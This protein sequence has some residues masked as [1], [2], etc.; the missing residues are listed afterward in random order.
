I[1]KEVFR[2]I[3]IEREKVNLSPLVWSDQILKYSTEKSKDMAQNNYFNHSDLNGK[4]TYNYMQADGISFNTWAENIIT[5]NNNSNVSSIA[6][7]MVNRWM[8]SS[9][10]KSN[11]LNSKVNTSAV[12]VFVKGNVIY[13]TQ[14]F[15]GK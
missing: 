3:N 11:I 15:L 10:H 12:G 4:Y 7:D 13:G 9:G 1:N 2:L 8:N 6:Q 5:A 14:I